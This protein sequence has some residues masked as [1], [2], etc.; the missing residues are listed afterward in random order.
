M[1]LYDDRSIRIR[2][3]GVPMTHREQQA[4]KEMLLGFSAEAIGTDAHYALRQ[5]GIRVRTL[6][7]GRQYIES[8]EE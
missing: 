2:A 5:V 8:T 7:S 4:V 6:S 3:F 1:A